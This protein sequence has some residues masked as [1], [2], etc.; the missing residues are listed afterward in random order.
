MSTP[1]RGHLTPEELSRSIIEESSLGKQSRDHLLVCPTC[2]RERQNLIEQLGKLG[3]IARR[4][5]P[6]P[7]RRVV[8]P[9]E[10]PVGRWARPFR[11]QL[12]FGAAVAF[13]L[14]LLTVSLSV[15]RGYFTDTPRTQISIAQEMAEDEALMAQVNVLV[16]D[17]LPE[18]YTEISPELE[19]DLGDDALDFVVPI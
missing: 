10:D 13:A 3:G 17:P 19:E 6:E 2:T 7:V 11:L 4:Y 8:L 5:A 9:S 16:E 1:E 18:A 14:V 15:Y 12:T